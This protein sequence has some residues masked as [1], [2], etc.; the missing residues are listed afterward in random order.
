MHMGWWARVRQA[1]SVGLTCLLLPLSVPALPQNAQPIGI[2][3]ATGRAQIGSS[4][5]SVGASVFAGDLLRTEAGDGMIVHVGKVQFFLHENSIATLYLRP[6]GAVAELEQGTL[7]FSTPVATDAVE[8]LVSDVRVLPKILGATVGEVSIVNPCELRV[9]S[10]VNPLQVLRG[11]SEHVVQEVTTYRVA[12]EHNIEVR[13]QRVSPDSP[14]FHNSHSH[15][16]CKVPPGWATQT[17]VPTWTIA[18]AFAFS[19]VTHW[20]TRHFPVS[21]H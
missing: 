14:D 7:T 3:T 5:A 15:K 17:K 2:V 16:P 20:I 1:G 18:A 19:G 10:Q 9:S 11:K 6:N 8:V 4:T 12:P 21:P 13:N